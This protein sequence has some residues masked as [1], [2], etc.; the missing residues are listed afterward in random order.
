VD[1]AVI[2][3][4]DVVSEVVTLFHASQSLAVVYDAVSLAVLVVVQ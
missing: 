1:D 4:T 3:V 2:A